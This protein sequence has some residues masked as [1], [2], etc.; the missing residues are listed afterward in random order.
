M[1]DDP[2]LGMNSHPLP[3]SGT[4]YGYLSYLPP[5]YHAKSGKHPLVLFLHGKGELGDGKTTL[6][7]L[8]KHGPFKLIKNDPTIFAEAN[9]VVLAPQGLKADNWWRW[10][11]LDNFLKHALREYNIDKDRIYLTGLSMG[12]GGTWM[13][14]NRHPHTFAAMVPICGAARPDKDITIGK[15]PVWA[16]HSVGDKVVSML[17]SEMWLDR[18]AGTQHKAKLMAGYPKAGIQSSSFDGREWSWTEGQHA[19]EGQ[20]GITVYPDTRHD[21]WTRAYQDPKLWE[22]L[23]AQKR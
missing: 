22:W 14:A 23:F 16:F 10:E 2:K 9:T 12:G 3:E 18:L 7:N 21:S 15:V 11:K 20:L 13:M 19:P 6:N 8:A 4:D 5:N 1:A 17:C